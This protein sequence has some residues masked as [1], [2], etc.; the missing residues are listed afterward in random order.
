MYTVVLAHPWHGSL[1]KAILDRVMEIVESKGEEYRLIDLNKDGFDPVLREKELKLFS[2][3]EALD[4]MVKDYQ[5]ALTDTEKLILIFPIW[6]YSAPA[7][8]K[9]FFDKVF[10]KGFAYESNGPL[11]K[12]KLKNIKEA[13]VITTSEG[14]TLFYKLFGGNPI[15]RVITG[16]TLK[17]VG[18]KKVKWI[19]SDQTSSQDSSKR[20]RFLN[21][22]YRYV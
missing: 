11:L 21:N 3:G 10:L 14:P 19:N 2:K 18:I 17:I 1:N 9:G 5:K 20:K 8:L 4:P 13:L 12:G 16:S 6:W 22:L 7:I 15:K